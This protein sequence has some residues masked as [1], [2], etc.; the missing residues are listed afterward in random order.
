M[1]LERE[2]LCHFK[3]VRV[4]QFSQARFAETVLEGA[5]HGSEENPQNIHHSKFFVLYGGE[6]QRIE[7][8]YGDTGNSSVQISAEHP[9][10]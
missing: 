1:V 9:W 7:E 2:N 10:T 3:P 4:Q 6:Q 5:L 8:I